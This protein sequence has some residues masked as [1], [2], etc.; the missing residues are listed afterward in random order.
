MLVDWVKYSSTPPAA[1]KLRVVMCRAGERP[2]L[3]LVQVPMNGL[4]LRVLDHGM[5]RP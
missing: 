4:A 1:E 3:Y 2:G 5:A